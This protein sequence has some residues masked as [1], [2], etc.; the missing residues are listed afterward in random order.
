MLVAAA[1][2]YKR[3]AIT[4]SAVLG[5]DIRVVAPQAA[6]EL[7]TINGVD[8]S[9]VIYKIGDIINV[10]ARSM[11]AMNVQLVME[12]LG[13]GGHQTMAAAQLKEESTT[14]AKR[15]LIEAIDNHLATLSK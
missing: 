7:L 4:E 9:F 11:G 8:A 13:G 3:C 1:E 6:D 10:S 2:I 15:R 5:E 14:V 12:L